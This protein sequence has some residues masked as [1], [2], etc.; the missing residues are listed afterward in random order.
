MN[1]V[2]NPEVKVYYFVAA[3]SGDMFT[4]T[5]LSGSPV[6][7]SSASLAYH[8]PKNIYWSAGTPYATCLSFAKG[9]RRGYGANER[10]GNKI[11]VLEIRMR[12]LQAYDDNVEACKHKLI[13]FAVVNCKSGTSN[14]V[15]LYD[16]FDANVHRPP[17][18][19]CNSIPKYNLESS[20]EIL[21]MSRIDSRFSLADSANTAYVRV[22]M[23][24][25]ILYNNGADGEMSTIF[26]NNVVLLFQVAPEEDAVSNSVIVSAAVYYTDI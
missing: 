25:P 5:N 15:P 26:R 7:G 3:L 8:D 10:I 11:N 23:N 20:Y 6:D 2:C 12:I 22:S 1:D 9:I 17:G 16:I 13:Q 4:S 21:H 19:I 14:S 24:K 18:N